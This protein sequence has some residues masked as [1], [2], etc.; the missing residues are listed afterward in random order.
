MIDQ[1]KIALISNKT[2]QGGGRRIPESVIERDYCLSWFLMGL[3]HFPIRDHLIFKGGTAL[4]RCYFPDYRFSEDLDFTLLK[5]IPLEPIL[6]AL[7]DVFEYIKEEAGIPFGIG[8]KE[9]PGVNTHTFTMTYEGPLPGKAREVKTDI[10]FREKILKPVHERPILKSYPEYSDFETDAKIRVYSLEEVV[11]E[12]ICA[13]LHPARSEPRD[14]YDVWYILKETGLNLPH[15]TADVA[16]KFEFKNLS[17]ESQACQL[18]KKEKRFEALWKKRLDP[19][20]SAL[21]EFADVYRTVKRFFR[22][23]GI[24][25]R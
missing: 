9:E 8:K 16:E 21:P 24:T 3:S 18:G 19:Q 25:K 22:Q 14:L 1:R 11:I 17:L 10:T 4:R 7:E 2:H 15:L 6:E 5:K 12:K 23:A 20:M 13:L